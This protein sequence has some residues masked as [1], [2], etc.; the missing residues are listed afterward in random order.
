M[1]SKNLN[2]GY[3]HETMDRIHIVYEN[4]DE[5]ILCQPGVTKSMRKQ[6]NKALGLLMDVYQKLGALGC[7]L[8][9]K[10]EQKI[11]DVGIRL[12]KNK[13]RKGESL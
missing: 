9:E 6:I 10:E 7:E 8:Q 5:H 4:I 2:S 13:K 12:L 1:K 3:C 11:I